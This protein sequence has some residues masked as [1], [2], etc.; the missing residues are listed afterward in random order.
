ML[1]IDYRHNKV[2]GNS[3]K[4]ISD[5]FHTLIFLILDI[6]IVLSTDSLNKNFLLSQGFLVNKLIHY[7]NNKVPGYWD[8]GILGYYGKEVVLTVK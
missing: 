3:G 1:S 6:L 5:C 7:R 8:I 4:Y 2:F